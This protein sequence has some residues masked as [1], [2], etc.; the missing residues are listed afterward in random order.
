ALMRA[1]R[2]RRRAAAAWL[3]R[4]TLALGCAM[5]VQAAA[6]ADEAVAGEAEMEA[7]AEPTL[8][9]AMPTAFDSYHMVFLM[10]AANP[11]A[12]DADAASDLQRRHLL[13]L[14]DLYDRGLSLVAGPFS[15]EA[16]EPMRG[17]VLF[18]GHFS[19][20]DVRRH[21]EADPA[22]Q[23]GRLRVEVRTW[24]T[25]AGQVRWPDDALAA[26]SADAAAGGDIGG[27]A[28]DDPPPRR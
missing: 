27:A 19:V 4:M 17:I 20:D 16:D 8:E 26:R 5:S 28:S 9:D 6:A 2:T 10:R 15:A 22:V 1:G 18:P 12:L 3:L 24:W 25:P 11:P 21:A 13:H 23:A 14:R 7:K